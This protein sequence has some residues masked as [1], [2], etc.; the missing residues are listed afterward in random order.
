MR[1]ALHIAASLT[2]AVACGAAG[3][4]D[5]LRTVKGLKLRRSR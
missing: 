1:S 4:A 2:F 3:A 5:E